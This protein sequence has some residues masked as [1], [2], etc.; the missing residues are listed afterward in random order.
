MSR[1]LAGEGGAIA[2][3]VAVFSLVMF[4]FAAIVVD[5]GM[6]RV[7]KADS[8][9]AA[10]AAAL[11]GA[12]A[13]YDDTTTPP[14]VNKPAAVRAVKDSAKRN[15]TAEAEWNG[16]TAS[17]PSPSWIRG[18]PTNT[19]IMF[20][21]AS[22]RI[23]VAIPPRRVD[24]AFGGVFGYSGSDVSASAQAQARDRSIQ[25]CALCV[26]DDLR[27]DGRVTVGGDGSAIAGTIDVNSGGLLELTAGAVDQ[28]AGIGWVDQLLG[29]ALP[30]SRYSPQP[31]QVPGS[32]DPLSAAVPMPLPALGDPEANN[33]NCGSGDRVRAFV[34]YR[35]VTVDAG[36]VFDPGLIVV[37]GSMH[38]SADVTTVNTTLYFTCRQ[39][40][41]VERC[42]APSGTGR[43]QVDSGVRLAMSGG[44]RA[45]GVRPI[46]VLFDPD[47]TSIMRV[48]GTLS[49]TNASLYKAA[50]EVRVSS[51]ASDVAALEVN[52]GYLSVADLFV[53]SRD[54]V[55]VSA[56]GVG[57]RPGPFRLALVK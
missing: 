25:D 40:N 45:A 28:G 18:D 9:A 22:R 53:D 4:G 52:E 29:P 23:F 8:A 12:A 49:V 57:S 16:C 43:L 44:Y 17:P 19:C 51:L 10:D 35:T 24:A 11:A 55:Q 42:P 1:R 2:V 31:E 20:D 38:I 3:L 26:A 47:N 7:T 39:G 30:S 33:Y 27:V 32:S 36:C 14:S 15:G 41:D 56:T 5:L 34:H 21:S 37:T 13:L 6:V 46:A 48:S 50:G 54:T